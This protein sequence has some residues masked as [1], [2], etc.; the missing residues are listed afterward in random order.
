[1]L[2]F[3]PQRVG[4]HSYLYKI[5]KEVK[6]IRLGDSK[7]VSIN[8][9]IGEEMLSLSPYSSQARKKVREGRTPKSY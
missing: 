3:S 6:N 4:L 2:I 1:M 8:Y 7:D 5:F 9:R